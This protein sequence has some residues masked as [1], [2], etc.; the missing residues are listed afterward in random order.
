MAAGAHYRRRVVVATALV[1]AVAV[2]ACGGS[3]APKAGGSNTS[4]GSQKAA[5]SPGYRFATCMRSHGVSNFPD[6]MVHQDSQQVIAI[7]KSP[8]FS[9][10]YRACRTT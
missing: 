8:A 5:E 6:P 9:S 7:K 4:A 2:A 1:T 10:A 3:S